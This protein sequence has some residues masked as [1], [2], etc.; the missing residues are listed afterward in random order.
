M[1]SVHKFESLISEYFGSRYAIATDSCTHAIELCLRYID[2]SAINCPNHTYLSVPMT[3]EKLGVSWFFNKEEWINYYLIGNTNIIDAATF[4]KENSYILGS[5]MCL[6]F[7]FKK[8][9]KLGRGGMILLDNKS[10]YNILRKMRYD[11]RDTDRPWADQDVKI[12]GYH[13]YM[14]PETAEEGI[15]K[16]HEVKDTPSREWSWKDYPNLK[17]M[18]VFKY[19]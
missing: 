4:W 17:K 9:L 3:F 12:L 13:Y 16:F 5:Y 11:G 14:T 7:Q 6:S 19:A 15:K 10:D 8:H 18:S 2:P 1:Q